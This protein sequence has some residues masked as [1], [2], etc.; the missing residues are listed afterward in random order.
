MTPIINYFEHGTLPDDRFEAK[1]LCRQAARFLLLDGILYQRGY[2]MPLLQCVSKENSRSLLEEVHERFFGDHV[3][4][5]KLSKYNHVTIQGYFWPTIN[6][7]SQDYVQKCDMCQR[8]SKI[9]R[10]APNDLK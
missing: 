8:I 4:G 10:A 2:S 1:K 9:P 6:E 5:A 3:E 7:D